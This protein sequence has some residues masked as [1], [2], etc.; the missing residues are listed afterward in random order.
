MVAVPARRRGIGLAGVVE[1]F[2]ELGDQFPAGALEEAAVEGEAAVPGLSGGLGVGLGGLV[3]DG[4]DLPFLAGIGC[5]CGSPGGV[6]FLARRARLPATM[7]SAKSWDCCWTSR[8][9]ASISGVDQCWR[10]RWPA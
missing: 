3:G 8:M 4:G 6:V 7:G 2:V 5:G 1:E 9:R 10:Q